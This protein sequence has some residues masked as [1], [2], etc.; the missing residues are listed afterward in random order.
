[1]LDDSKLVK[2]QFFVDKILEVVKNK[3]KKNINESQ[4]RIVL[5]AIPLA[6]QEILI[7]NDKVKIEGLGVFKPKVIPKLKSKG[8]VNDEKL[9]QKRIV[10]FDYSKK[11]RET[12]NKSMQEYDEKNSGDSIEQ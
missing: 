4:V 12:T 7:N 10:H 8:N 5:S 2:K 6:I 3:L 9:K 11:F 1:M